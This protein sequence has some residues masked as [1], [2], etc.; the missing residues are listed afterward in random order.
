MFR[1]RFRGRGFSNA[2]IPNPHGQNFPA[3]HQPYQRHVNNRPFFL[4]NQVNYGFTHGHQPQGPVY[5]YPQD[6]VPLYNQTYP[7]QQVRFQQNQEGVG[8][9]QQPGQQERSNR[10]RHLDI[11]EDS[12]SKRS[13]ENDNATNVTIQDVPLP[14]PD[15]SRNSLISQKIIENFVQNHQTEQDYNRKLHLRDALYTILQGVIPNCGLYIVGSS[16]TGFS[17]T[18]SDMDLCLVISDQEDVFSTDRDIRDLRFDT[19]IVFKSENEQTLG[20][21]FLG[22]LDYYANSFK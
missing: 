20:D 21:L 9:H 22:F 13:R 19:S 2:L 11:E 7:V 1:P 8:V 15:Y 16:M 18:K 6:N 17:T 12:R 5:N 3:F 10:K 4:T 14:P